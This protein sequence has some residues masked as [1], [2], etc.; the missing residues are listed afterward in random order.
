MELDHEPPLVLQ[1]HL[2]D[3][4]LERAQRLAAAR[5]AQAAHLYRV[6]HAIRREPEERRARLAQ[7]TDFPA[8]TMSVVPVM[9]D[10]SAHDRN[11]IG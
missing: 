11:R 9:N 6:E 3:A 4:I 10:D 1:L 2:V 7:M 5:A 8:S